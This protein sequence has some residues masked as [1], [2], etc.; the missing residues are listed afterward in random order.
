MIARGHRTALPRTQGADDVPVLLPGHFPGLRRGQLLGLL[1]AILAWALCRLLIYLVYGE[2][3]LRV[4]A[5]F[6]EIIL[7]LPVQLWRPGR[8][9][10]RPL[11]LNSR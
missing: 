2:R 11:A 9:T 7:Q 6:I 3:K 10:V 8:H 1:L 5:G 4:C